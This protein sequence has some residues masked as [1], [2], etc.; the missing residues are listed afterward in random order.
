MKKKEVGEE[1]GRIIAEVSWGGVEPSELRPEDRLRED[2][3]LDSVA[4]VDLIV[5]LEGAYGIRVDPLDLRVAEAFSTYG[6]LLEFALERM[7]KE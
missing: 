1:L 7:V 4:L 6:N 5:A 3:G 2:I